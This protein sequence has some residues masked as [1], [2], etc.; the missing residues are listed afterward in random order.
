MRFAYVPVVVLLAAMAVG[1]AAPAPAAVPENPTAPSDTAKP[2]EA[3]VAPEA[4][5]ITIPGVCEAPSAKAA[6]T[7]GATQKS[8]ADC[9]TVITRSQFESLANA[10]QPNMNPQTKRRL[11][12][13]Y[14]RMMVMAHEARK[15][16]LENQ[17]KYKEMMKFARLQIL[18]QE[19]SRS[20]KEDADKVPAA[21]IE[22]YYK[23]NPEAFEQATLLRL[24][25]PKEKQEAPEKAEVSGK[26]EE[27]ED[28]A[29]AA[30]KSKADEQ[31][32]QQLAQD[33]QKRASAGE[34]FD[35]L[36]KEA[37]EKSGITGAAPTTNIGKLGRN[38]L[39]VSQR[40]VLDLKAGEVS[41]LITESNGYYVYKV[42]SK[43]T[44]SLDQ[45]RDEI[46]S[47]LAQQ[48]MQDAMSKF[49]QEGQA[50]L[51]DAYFG[52][53]SG[54]AVPSRRGPGGAQPPAGAKPAGPP[55]SPANPPAGASQPPQK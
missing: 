51:N 53:A 14:P 28:T 47:T 30:E 20:V 5:V 48:R 31:A 4:A 44:K 39:P 10:L 11:A 24:F 17:P 2:A 43:E 52:P 16:G 25:V 42:Q 54:A 19:L 40:T 15:R 3:K 23:A 49:Q 27:S 7:K 8:K 21:Q 41:Q 33:I 38:E 46:R 1:Q 9:K 13:V 32:M 36:Q 12:E 34:D 26:A 22:E 55:A 37:Y 35:K 6:G 45:S 18:S 29:K 50:Q